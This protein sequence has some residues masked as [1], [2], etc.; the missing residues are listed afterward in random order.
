MVN[1][2]QTVHYCLGLVYALHLAF[3][4]TSAD[5]MRKHKPHCKAMAAEYWEEEV[6]EEDNS[7]EDEGY[8]P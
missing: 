2:L 1:H 3:F 7:D 5:T 6:L 4:T 8:F